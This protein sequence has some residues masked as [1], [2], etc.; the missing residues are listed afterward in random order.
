MTGK[1]IINLLPSIRGAI[2]ATLAGKHE[3]SYIR[4]TKAQVREWARPLWSVETTMALIEHDNS[5]I[6]YLDVEN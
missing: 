2:F 3:V 4:V 6:W 1:E 5:G